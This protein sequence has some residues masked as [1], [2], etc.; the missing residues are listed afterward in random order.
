MPR[1]WALLGLFDAL[2]EAMSHECGE[3][4]HLNWTSVREDLI[5]Y[6]TLSE[7]V[8]RSRRCFGDTGIWSYCGIAAMNILQMQPGLLSNSQSMLS[9]ANWENPC[10]IGQVATNLFAMSFLT[11]G[12]RYGMLWVAGDRLE[13]LSLNFQSLLT[14]GW[15]M[16]GLLSRLAEVIQ[17]SNQA[18]PVDACA[19]AACEQL[20]QLRLELRRRVA[21][22]GLAPEAL[23]RRVLAA[24]ERVAQAKGG[25][26]GLRLGVESFSLAA[27]KIWLL[28]L[29]AVAE[30]AT[31]AV[32]LSADGELW[33]FPM[34]DPAKRI[35]R[36]EENAY[37][38]QDQAELQL[39]DTMVRILTN[40]TDYVHAFL[41]GLKSEAAAAHTGITLALV[42]TLLCAMLLFYMVN[43]P[44]KDLQVSTWQLLSGN[45][46]LFCTVMLF[47]ALKK[48]WKLMVGDKAAEWVIAGDILAFLKFALLMFS[49]PF[50]RSKIKN[51]KLLAAAKTSGAYLIG[52]AGSDSFAYIL[53]L[54]PFS[55]GSGYYF[56][57]MVLMFAVLAGLMAMAF[58]LGQPPEEYD[59]SR[60]AG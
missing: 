46:A 54:E 13:K 39:P 6:S 2:G 32:Q 7:P 60:E 52:F 18:R 10:K 22:R 20:A 4:P 19:G 9:K 17:L 45:I 48:S 27:V 12:E 1:L 11:P 16:F 35:M 23:A 37:V 29:L 34:E 14:S 57:G 25:S 31:H 8:M 33:D 43:Q 21:E 36:Q 40:N 58:R 55:S 42:G 51:E 41:R 50:V 59:P 56:M 30:A 26:A 5:T 28:S 24:V 38:Q 47:M 44:N 3:Q 53:R 49:F 15:P